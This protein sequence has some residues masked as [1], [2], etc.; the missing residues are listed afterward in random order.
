MLFDQRSVPWRK[1][2][3]D[4][5]RALSTGDARRPTRMRWLVRSCDLS[6]LRNRRR[7]SPSVQPRPSRKSS[8][9]RASAACQWGISSGH[10][11]GL[12][13]HL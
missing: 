2:H 13:P 8:G 7:I 3:V 10:R 11:L 1:T 6:V 5:E 4:T 9:G 12:F